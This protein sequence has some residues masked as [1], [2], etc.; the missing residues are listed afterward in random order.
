MCFVVTDTLMYSAGAQQP[1]SAPC[2]V[3]YVASLLS[4]ILLAD[5]F[6]ASNNLPRQYV[7]ESK[8]AVSAS[9]HAS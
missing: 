8:H 5:S 3:L 9:T 2:L 6:S 4:V 1:C 7:E